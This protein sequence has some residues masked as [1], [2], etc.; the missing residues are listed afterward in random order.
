MKNFNTSPV[1]NVFGL[2]IF[3]NV[4]QSFLIIPS[5]LSYIVIVSSCQ[6]SRKMSDVATYRQSFKNSLLFLTQIA[7]KRE[8]QTFKEYSFCVNFVVY[9]YLPCGKKSYKSWEKRA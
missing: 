2:C 6:T 8:T 4:K 3:V 1:W 7:T 5:F 9:L